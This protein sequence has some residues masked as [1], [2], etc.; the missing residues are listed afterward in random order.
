MSDYL[1]DRSGPV[2]PGVVDLEARLK[3]LAFDA[4]KH[5]LV[6]PPRRRTVPV[7]AAGMAASIAIIA[8]LSTF[9]VW[10]LQWETSRPWSIRGGGSFAIGAPLHVGSTP[11]T[12][13]IARLGVL[14]ATSGTDLSL[15]ETSSPRH[16][17]TMARG[18]IDVR[19]W[20]PPGRVAVH[21]PAGDVVDLGCIF[22]LSVDA[23]G[24]A[25]LTVRT[26]WVELRNA[27][28]EAAIPAG[29]S[30]SM[31][32]DREP[33]V[34][35]YDDA[36]ATFRH[37]VRAIESRGHPVDA[38]L[39]QTVAM[40]AR[41]RDAITVLTLSNVAG[42]SPD[43]RTALLETARLLHDPPTADAVP[44]IV[45]GDRDLFWQ[46]FD[47]LPLPRLK[48]WWANWRDAFPR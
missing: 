8:G 13:N 37:A 45:A 1:W 20:A 31:S 21:T 34:A 43:A 42:L 22:S 16:R 24:A 11:A 4:R 6:S 5:P 27:H 33:Q 9:H 10:R 35:V 29:A 17:F 14:Q 12:V 32:S 41:P 23:S 36:S 26:G 48:N 30:A 2:D 28:G 46:W 19:L 25:H 15:D 7:F 18:G 47:S 39:L 3:P 40:Q 38:R 44:R